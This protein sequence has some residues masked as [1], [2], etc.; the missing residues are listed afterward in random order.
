MKTF[1]PKP[2][3]LPQPVL[4]IGTYDKDGTPN[5][6]NAAWGGQWDA[7]QV[8]ISM[9]MHA[10]TDNLERD[11]EFTV[12]FATAGTMAAT[13]YVGN[14]SGRKVADKVRRTGWTAVKGEKVN[15]PVFTDFPMTLECRV[16]RKIDPSSTGFF[17]VGDI[18]AVRVN[19]EYL[20]ED[21]LPDVGKMKLI[22]FDPVHHGYVQ[23]G[24]KVGQ[25]FSEFKK[26]G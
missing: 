22:V 6:M 17:L 7:A 3:A 8:F 5:A 19:E 12:A 2:W 20:S 18:L 16:A 23:L 15:A 26:L 13:D 25:A 1:D 4:V 10:T 24:D 14:V 11:D 9:G 21:G